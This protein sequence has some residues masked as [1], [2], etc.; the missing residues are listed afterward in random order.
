MPHPARSA[1][2]EFTTANAFYVQTPR[3]VR[4]STERRRE[5]AVCLQ[6]SHTLC[7]D[8][9]DEWP[10]SP[11]SPLPPSPFLSPPALYLL[12]DPFNYLLH[13]LGRQQT[14]AQYTGLQ[15]IQHTYTAG[16][17]QSGY[18]V[19]LITWLDTEL[20]SHFNQDNLLWI[21]SV[22]FWFLKIMLSVYFT[23]KIKTLH[24]T[25]RDL[26]CCYR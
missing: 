26:K 24:T 8:C 25:L 18:F 5:V 19:E 23:L 11:I 1:E 4:T 20:C 13:I 22:V 10:V 2:S 12:M 9:K 7:T 3:R 17:R 21:V 14:R 6:S 15:M 16:T